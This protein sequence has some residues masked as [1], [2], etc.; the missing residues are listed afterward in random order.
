MAV[1]PNRIAYFHES[2]VEN[3]G[4]PAT[5]A[6]IVGQAVRLWRVR[7]HER[8]FHRDAAIHYDIQTSRIRSSAMSRVLSGR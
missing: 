1:F 7:F 2:K 5:L 4:L 8:P 3:N 6:N